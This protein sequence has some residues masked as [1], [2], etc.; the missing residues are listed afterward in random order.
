MAGKKGT[1]KTVKGNTKGKKQTKKKRTR[2]YK[3]N[4]N[5]SR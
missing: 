1:G 5:K 4:E 2:I 3:K